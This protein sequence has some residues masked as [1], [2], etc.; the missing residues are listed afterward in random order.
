VKCCRKL[1][2]KGLYGD[3]ARMQEFIR[4]FR[5]IVTEKVAEIP[6][7]DRLKSG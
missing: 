1:T 4:V 3:T 7:H 6:E 2:V 5:S